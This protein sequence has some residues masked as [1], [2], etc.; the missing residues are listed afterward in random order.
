MF[1]FMVV[2]AAACYDSLCRRSSACTFV[3]SWS[4]M[5]LHDA[6]RRTENPLTV[7]CI[8]LWQRVQLHDALR[9]AK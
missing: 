8:D 6:P 7:F 4:R 5:Q 9:R 3:G 1:S 2:G